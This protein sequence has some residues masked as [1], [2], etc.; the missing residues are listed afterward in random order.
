MANYRTS[1]L[2]P[3]VLTIVIIIVVIA[4]F[5]ALGRLIF[6]GSS[7]TEVI[8]TSQQALLDSSDGHAVSM[9]VRGPIVADEDFHSY[10]IT[11][12]PS[13]R[14]FQAFTGYLDVIRNQETL[15]NNTAAYEEFVHALDK[16]NL[17]AGNPFEGDKNDVRGICATGKVYEFRIIAANDVEEMLWTSTCSGSPGSLKASANQLSALFLNQIP[18]SSKITSDLKL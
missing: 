2:V 8:D 18:N 6:G 4:G 12:S 7:N 1:R 5:I 3:T 11:I 10:R 16:A 14:E 15:A 9:T 17:V 13:A